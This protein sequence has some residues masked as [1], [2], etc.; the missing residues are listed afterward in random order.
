[1]IGSIYFAV[2]HCIDSTWLNDR[3][4]FLFPKDG[5]QTD[6]EFQNDCL[7]FALFHGQNRISSSE[8]VNHWIPF[9]EA[10]VYAKEKFGSNFMTDYIKGKLKVEQKNSL[11]KENVTFGVYKN[12]VLEFSDEAKCVF[13]AGRELWKY[14]HSQKDINVNASFYEIREHFQGRSAKG[15]MNSKS[16]DEN[17]TSLLAELKDKLNIIA[18]KITPKVYKYE[19]LKS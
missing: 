14:Y 19:F 6:S 8:G 16:N 2:R 4:Q 15:I 17:Y 13:V 11:F 18:E 9:T 12:E 1:M 7:T 10:E 5:W 3:D